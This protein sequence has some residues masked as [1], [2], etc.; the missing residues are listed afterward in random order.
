MR[1]SNVKV[2][3]LERLGSTLKPEDDE[4]FPAG[5]HRLVEVIDAIAR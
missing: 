3:L 5:F 4:P 2:I 1:G